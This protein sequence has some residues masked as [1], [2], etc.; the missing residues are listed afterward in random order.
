MLPDAR[1][2]SGSYCAQSGQE[3]GE[4]NHYR[5]LQ[6]R[7]RVSPATADGALRHESRRFLI[8]RQDRR[9]TLETTWTAAGQWFI[10]RE[11][12]V[13]LWLS[14]SSQGGNRAKGGHAPSSVSRNRRQTK[15]CS[16][17]FRSVSYITL[18]CHWACLGRIPIA[19]RCR[20]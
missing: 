10:R 20:V 11:D 13:L 3:G 7:F 16:P 12:V 6:L 19:R 5:W 8:H 1:L 18:S 15:Y 4:D 14:V 17:G 2:K 9:Q